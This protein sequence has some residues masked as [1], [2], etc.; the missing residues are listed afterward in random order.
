[1]HWIDFWVVN[2]FSEQLFRG[3]PAGVVL[4]EGELSNEELGL[5][6][7]TM[8]ACE[9]VFVLPS[10]R[11]DLRLRCFT[12]TC[13]LAFSGHAFLAALHLLAEIGRVDT[14][15]ELKIETLSGIVNCSWERFGPDLLPMLEIPLPRFE[16][17]DIDRDALAEALLVST[18]AFHPHWTM[19]THALYLLVPF[20]HRHTL[21]NLY[22]DFR[23][24]SRLG[25]EHD[26]TSFVCFA[27]TEQQD[28]DW[29]LRLFA[30][31][32]GVNEDLVSGTAHGVVAAYLIEQGILPCRHG[33]NNFWQGEQGD[34][35]KQRGQVR[36]VCHTE[37]TGHPAQIRIGGFAI[38]AVQGRLRVS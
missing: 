34:Y 27:E 21:L 36:V 10:Q 22:P 30:P 4:D 24:L 20:Q 17:I 2:S 3:N 32:L 38:T 37:A 33:A 23:R 26:V 5:I 28:L 11:A 7:Q 13:E 8:C 16:A 25:L 12:S 9:T 31:G 6:A 15:A 1:M 35:M 19:Q 14:G 18:E 29:S